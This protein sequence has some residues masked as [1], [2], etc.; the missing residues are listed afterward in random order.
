MATGVA[1]LPE[2]SCGCSQCSQS[3]LL[4]VLL[5]PAT[6]LFARQVEIAARHTPHSCT[7]IPLGRLDDVGLWAKVGPNDRR[8]ST[9]R[10]R[11]GGQTCKVSSCRVEYSTVQSIATFIH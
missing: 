3:V 1:C 7:I 11:Q 5:L 8:Y 6:L 4:S 10:R 2:P 9:L